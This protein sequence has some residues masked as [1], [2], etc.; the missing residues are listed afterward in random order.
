M[1]FHGLMRKAAFDNSKEEQLT[2]VKNELPDG[3]VFFVLRSLFAPG[4]SFSQFRLS[5]LMTN[6]AP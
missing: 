5:S 1:V 3:R 4:R 2:R 6:K